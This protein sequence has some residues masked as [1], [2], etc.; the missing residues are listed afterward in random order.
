LCFL[1]S[2]TFLRFEAD[3]WFYH[4]KIHYLGPL[5]HQER[6]SVLKRRACACHRGEDKNLR[7][8]SH[9]I[10]EP[11]PRRTM[12]Q[13]ATLNSTTGKNHN[14]CVCRGFSVLSS[15]LANRMFSFSLS[16]SLSR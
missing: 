15:W 4:G 10:N 6:F 1:S 16:L 12:L 8:S 9:A 7:A 2:L 13:R 14:I 5:L 3:R 11:K